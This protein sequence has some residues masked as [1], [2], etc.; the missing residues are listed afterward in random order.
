MPYVFMEEL[1]EGMEPAD[2]RTAE[3]Y[4]TL[5]DALTSITTERDELS[6]KYEDMVSKCDAVSKELDD[7]KRKFAS[8]FLTSTDRQVSQPEP[9]PAYVPKTFDTLFS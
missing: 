1:G 7:A 4:N 8:A 9:E 2:V 6:A 5:N 3:E